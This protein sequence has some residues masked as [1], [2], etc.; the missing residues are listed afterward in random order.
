M[1]QFRYRHNDPA[2]V[3][4][5]SACGVDITDPTAANLCVNTKTGDS[6]IY[7]AYDPTCDP[8]ETPW[9]RLVWA[10]YDLMPRELKAKPKKIV[11]Y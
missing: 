8:G 2:F 10:M 3:P 9:V 5:C 1:I 4:V 6:G 11:N 7:H